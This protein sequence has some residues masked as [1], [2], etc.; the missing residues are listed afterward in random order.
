MQTSHIEI[1][2]TTKKIQFTVGFTH[3]YDRYF[4]GH[5][6]FDHQSAASV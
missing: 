5:D 6:V 1:K 3:D 2:L 4:V